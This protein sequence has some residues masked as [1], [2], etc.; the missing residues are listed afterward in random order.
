MSNL[1]EAA[2]NHSPDGCRFGRFT[3]K[4][5]FPTFEVFI[6]IEEFKNITGGVYG[7]PDG[8]KYFKSQI[9]EKYIYLRCALYKATKC[10]W[11]FEM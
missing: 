1:R 10:L 6:T 7:I 11:K 5:I 3:C 4:Y 9:L 8:H 2:Q